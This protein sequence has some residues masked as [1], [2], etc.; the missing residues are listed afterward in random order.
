MHDFTFAVR[1]RLLTLCVIAA[2]AAPAGAQNFVCDGIGPRLLNFDLIADK[3]DARLSP[4]STEGEPYS[5]QIDLRTCV[6]Q[7][8]FQ[9]TYISHFQSGGG[10]V[11]LVATAAKGVAV[12]FRKITQGAQYR[13]FVDGDL[14]T[15]GGSVVGEFTPDD[16][17]GTLDTTGLHPAVADCGQARI[18]AL[19]AS[20]EFAALPA[21]RSFG[22]T[23]VAP[24]SDFEIIAAPGEVIHFDSLTLQGEYDADDP[25]MCD[26]QSVIEVDGGPAVINVDR[27]TIGNCVSVVSDAPIVFNVPGRGAQVRIGRGALFTMPILA[28]ERVI[29]AIG[30]LDDQATNLGAMWGRQ[31]KLRGL[32][33]PSWD[34]EGCDP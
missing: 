13:S 3:I 16:I 26:D 4:S 12:K 19:T 29:S 1:S 28:P 27:L 25:E 23:T 2:L 22:P 17:D 5:G 34:F 32:V 15:G 9:G 18:D 10:P 7:G 31:I 11:T 14:V 24:F 21:D 8:R 6:R 33:F 20:A 30:T